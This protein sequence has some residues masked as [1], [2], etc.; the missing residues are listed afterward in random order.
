MKTLYAYIAVLVLLVGCDSPADPVEDPDAGIEEFYSIISVPDWSECVLDYE[1]DARH[2]GEGYY[3]T[4]DSLIL[5]ASPNRTAYA[6]Q[7]VR[8]NGAEVWFG[9]ESH[10]CRGEYN[11]EN[12]IGRIIAD[13]KN[14][15]PGAIETYTFQRVQ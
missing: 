11:G 10:A 7:T 9:T 6:L 8:C 4:R 14:G 15:R 12:I 2:Y 3:L 13:G 5:Y 1:Y